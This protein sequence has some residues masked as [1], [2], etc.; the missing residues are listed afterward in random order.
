MYGAGAII[1][2][3]LA[4]GL[5]TAAGPTGLYWFTAGT[6][7]LLVTYTIYRMLRRESVPADQHTAFVD[8]LASAQTA[9]HVYEEEIQHAAE[10]EEASTAGAG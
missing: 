6:H 8:A 10:A 5:M 3:F 7:V 9:S 4:S 2:P 1:G